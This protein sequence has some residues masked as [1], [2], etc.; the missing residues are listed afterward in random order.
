MAVRQTV[1]FILSRKES[2]HS[3]SKSGFNAILDGYSFDCDKSF[4][5]ASTGILQHY[6]RCQVS[7]CKSR[8]ITDDAGTVLK[9]CKPHSHDP[10]KRKVSPK[11]IFDSCFLG[12]D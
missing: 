8:I 5:P 1:M 2:K 12:C 7:S 3:S 11:F 4:T 10:P 9:S 6:W